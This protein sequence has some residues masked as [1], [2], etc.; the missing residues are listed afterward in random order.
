MII[1]KRAYCPL[2]TVK[3][4][5]DNE[6]EQINN[7]L[8]STCLFL[9]NF[10]HLKFGDELFLTKLFLITNESSEDI[11]NLA[12]MA[13]EV[14]IDIKK[15]DKVKLKE[16][17]NLAKNLSKSI[18]DVTNDNNE[19]LTY[20]IRTYKERKN[21]NSSQILKFFKW[22]ID[23]KHIDDPNLL[24]FIYINEKRLVI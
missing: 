24:L 23:N 6:R 21:R 19:I 15:L 8:N 18:N 14:Y 17:T 11:N 13:T 20:A 5:I 22:L 4:T 16:L 1:L 7:F 12:D 2:L 3:I 9:S 10:Y